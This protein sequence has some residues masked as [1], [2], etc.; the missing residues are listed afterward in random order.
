MCDRLHN[1]ELW[2]HSWHCSLFDSSANNGDI[3]ENTGDGFKVPES[4]DGQGQKR[5]RSHSTAV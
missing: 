2:R 4:K 1:R 5:P 3:G